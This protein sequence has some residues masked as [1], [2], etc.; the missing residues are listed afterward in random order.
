MHVVDPDLH[1]YATPIVAATISNAVGSAFALCR[2]GKGNVAVAFFGDGA[3]EEGRFYESLNLASLYQLPVLFVCENNLYA[4]HVRLE[5]RRRNP[6]LYVLADFFDMPGVQ[7]D[8]NDVCRVYLTAQEAT[9][10]A[11]CGGGPTFI[12]CLT[13]RWRGHV[14]PHYDLDKGI[15]DAQELAAWQTRCPIEQLADILLR[16]GIQSQ[17]ELAAVRLEI[18]QAVAQAWE[19]ANSSPLPEPDQLLTHVYSNAGED[20]K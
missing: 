5:A 14:G 11:R 15:R 16:E 17:D 12:E 2:Q 13:Y 19:F 9:E 8:G 7:V 4:S 1:V 18:E 3:V 6:D 20:E 10:R